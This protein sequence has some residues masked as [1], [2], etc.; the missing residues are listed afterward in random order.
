AGAAKSALHFVDDQ[1]GIILVGDLPK[2]RQKVGMRHDHAA[3]A[4]DRLDDDAGDVG[5]LPLQRVT[6]QIDAGDSTRFWLKANRT[7]ITVGVWRADHGQG[8]G[9]VIAVRRLTRRQRQ[10][11]AGAAVKGGAKG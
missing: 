10:R 7:T 5:S 3:F 4:T 6:K 9:K 1:P 8:L 2:A 11:V